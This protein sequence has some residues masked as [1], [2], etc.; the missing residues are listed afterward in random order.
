MNNQQ[1]SPG[2]PLPNQVCFLGPDADNTYVTPSPNTRRGCWAPAR[3]GN[4]TGHQ[5]NRTVVRSNRTPDQQSFLDR[6]NSSQ[7][8]HA[9]FRHSNGAL[10]SPIAS[11]NMVT[12]IG[13][14][15][16][17]PSTWPSLDLDD[18]RPDDTRLEDP[19]PDD[20]SDP[21]EC[22]NLGDTESP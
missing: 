20:L 10:I 6:L 3:P 4:R 13:T 21:F 7:V 12:F 11:N 1:I 2:R 22:F 5:S 17:H 16:T 15:R 9:P 18:P 8:H 14:Y 19:R